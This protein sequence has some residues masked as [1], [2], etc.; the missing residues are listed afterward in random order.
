MSWRAIN[1]EYPLHTE[2]SNLT[3]LGD[4]YYFMAQKYP[5]LD[6]GHMIP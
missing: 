1:I 4:F 5:N 6:F 2:V 3:A